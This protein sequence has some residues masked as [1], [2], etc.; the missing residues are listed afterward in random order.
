MTSTGTFV[1]NGIERVVVSQLIRSAGA[2]FTTESLRGRKFYGAKIIPNRGA[3]L[4]FE[5]DASGFIGVK[6]DRKRKVAATTILRAF[7]VEKFDASLKE[8][9]EKDTTKTQAE[10]VVEVYRRLRPGDLATSDSA[11]ELINN[12]FFNFERYDLSKVGRWK[13]LQR[14]PELNSKEK[15]IITVEDPVEYKLNRI[16]QIQMKQK[17]NLTFANTLRSILRQDPDIIM[18]GEIRDAETATNCGSSSLNR[19]I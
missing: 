11:Q 13:T 18:V 7:G 4:E 9:L 3:W 2:F 5:S 1:I 8:T 16:N 15:N 6:I 19:A 12:M 17:I 10:A 14:L